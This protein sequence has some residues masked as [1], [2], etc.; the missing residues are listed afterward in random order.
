MKKSGYT[1]VEILVVLVIISM[2]ALLTLPATKKART[3]AA[4]LKTKAIIAS[5]EAALSM[6]QTDMGNYPESTG[7]SVIL[8]EALMGPMDDENWKGPYMRFK[9]KDVD[10]NK[11]VIDTW[12]NPL[13][14]VYPQNEKSN[15]PFIIVS[16]G[17]DKKF[18]TADDIGNW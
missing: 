3:K 2:L 7:S 17:P 10:E 16:S 4:I 5:I 8:I 14:Y 13:K 11:N 9:Q 12:G 1:L 18:E 6:Y 15:V